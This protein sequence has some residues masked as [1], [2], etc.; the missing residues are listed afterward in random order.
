MVTIYGL[1]DKIG[2]LTYYDSSGQAD[3]NFNKP[4]S[5]KTAELIDKEISNIIEFQYNRAIDILEKHKDKLT[6]L[7]N[8]LLDKEVIFKETL[9]RIFGK[10]PFE[11]D[12]PQSEEPKVATS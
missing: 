10:R 8:E 6:V 12:T 11:K 4:Y 2:N 5:E 1:N 7:A 9:E 3:Y